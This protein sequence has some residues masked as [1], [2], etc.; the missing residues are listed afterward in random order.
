MTMNV[1]TPEVFL[2][3]LIV[4]SWQLLFVVYICTGIMDEANI[5]L[6]YP[7]VTIVIIKH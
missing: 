7:W 1:A 4:P 2:L 5:L 6:L 3:D